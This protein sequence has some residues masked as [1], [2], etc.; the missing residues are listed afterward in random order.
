[1][2]PLRSMTVKLSVLTCLFVLGVIGLMA[3][4]LLQKTE[5]GL[6]TEMKVRAEFFARASR[7][8][9]FP[10]VDAF[11]LHFN[12]KELLKEKAVTYAAVLD[13]SGKVLS[14]SDP[15]QIGER[16]ADPRTAAALKAEG[17][18]LQAYR[19][20]S[21]EDAYDLSAPI[22][23]ATRRVGTARLGFDNS[24]VQ[25]ALR[26]PKRQILAIAAGST[27]LAVLG[28]TLI[29]GWMIRPLPRLAEAVRE[30]G[31]GNFDVQVEA[32][33]RDEIG[34]VARAFNEMAV[35]NKLLFAAIKEEKEKLESIFHDTQEGLVLTDPKGRVLLIN[36]AARA[37][38]GCPEKPALALAEAAAAF[39]VSP[40]LP[41]VLKG[42]ERAVILELRRSKPKL[43]ILDGVADRLG[44]AGSHA[45]FLFILR[46][47]TLE[48]RGET[49]ARNLLS[50]VS[51]KLRTPLAVALGFLEL[52]ESD[53]E[54][55]TDFQKQALKKI[56]QEDEHLRGLV[57]KLLTFSAAQSPETIVLERAELSLPDV[58]AAALKSL[59]NAFP[60]RTLPV[61]WPKEGFAK[62][63]RFEGDPLLLKEVL[64][65]LLENAF[66]FNRREDKTAKIAALVKDGRLRV[67]VLD[68]GPGIPSEE[69]P[70]LF[71][72]FY[73]IDEDFTGQ[74][75]GMGLGLA[76]VKNVV[77]AHG[78]EVGLDSQTGKGSEFW[79]TLPLK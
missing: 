11:N 65:N 36:A 67:S 40:P 6:F 21:G 58:V 73:Q 28:T 35:A 29:V 56:Q 59:A 26:Q 57:E 45:G 34:V 68:N 79:F 5:Q 37:L 72:K 54:N 69:R 4:R 17:L 22:I 39:E 60:G 9:I 13:A 66:K 71:R 25:D 44:P 1:M 55:L 74:I 12:V 32:S 64:F 42:A 75:P 62:L 61:S 38:L 43:L 46:D 30:V 63:P 78:G 20:A 7:E 8:S 2:N 47:A 23:V 15:A 31:R 27:L 3:Q 52:M 14:H 18:L 70:K 16:P 49:L 53:R 77:G 51:H 48:K 19:S 24:S 33:N 10:K 76:F 41:E 50:L